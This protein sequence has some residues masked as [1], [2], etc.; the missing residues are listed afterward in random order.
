MD[1]HALVEVST[2]SNWSALPPSPQEPDSLAMF[3][4]S[5]ISYKYGRAQHFF[6]MPGL[7]VA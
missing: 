3:V 7:P 2:G 1:I 5:V 6:S 4:G